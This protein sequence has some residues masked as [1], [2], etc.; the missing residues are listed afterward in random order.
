MSTLTAS[1]TPSDT[2]MGPRE[3]CVFKN[4]ASGVGYY[5][6]ATTSSTSSASS[7]TTSSSTSSSTKNTN[8]SN[9]SSG[10]EDELDADADS[11]PYPTNTSNLSARQKRLLQLRRRMNKARKSN[12][13]EILSEGRRLTDPKYKQRKRKA[14]TNKQHQEWENT[15]TARGL[16]ADQY[17][18]LTTAARAEREEG[19]AERKRQKKGAFGWEAFNA[20]TLLK[21]H[22]KRAA[23]AMKKKQRASRGSSKGSSSDGGPS[24]LADAPSSSAIDSMVSELDDREKLRSKWSRRREVYGDEHMNHIN[25]YNRNY[26]RSINRAYDKYTVDIR[27]A[28]ERGTG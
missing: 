16:D 24:L 10:Q 3:N 20:D 9:D 21:G 5:K 19:A 12:H 23:A 1:F 18:M 6:D 14:Q 25:E 15:I 8:N 28:L 4:G 17:H 22:E 13:Q 26:N 7:T 11:P 27:Q 2:F